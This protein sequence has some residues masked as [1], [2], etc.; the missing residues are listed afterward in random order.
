MNILQTRTNAFK[1]KILALTVAAL[2]FT[3]IV[4]ADI[5]VKNNTDLPITVSESNLRADVSNGSQTG[6][7]YLSNGTVSVEPGAFELINISTHGGGKSYRSLTLDFRNNTEQ[8]ALNRL[9]VNCV[10]YSC[11]YAT[12]DTLGIDK[13]YT[14]QALQLDDDEVYVIDEIGTLGSILRR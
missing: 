3:P 6:N 12:D 2:A 10:S 5:Y 7:T 4:Q 9:S 11:A 8:L 1:S 14:L 13:D